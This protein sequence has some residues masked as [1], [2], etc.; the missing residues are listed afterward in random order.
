MP[1]LHAIAVVT[2]TTSRY[3]GP[4]DVHTY[5]GYDAAAAPKERPG[6]THTYTVNIAVA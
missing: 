5:E 6:F 3:R 2:T 4:L 1:C